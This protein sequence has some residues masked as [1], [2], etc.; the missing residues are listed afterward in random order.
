VD[1]LNRIWSRVEKPAI[2]LTLGAYFVLQSLMLFIPR[3]DSIVRENPQI[4]GLFVSVVLFYLFLFVD[5]RLPTE[6][7]DAIRYFDNLMSAVDCAFAKQP[8]AKRIDILGHSTQT[9]YASIADRLQEGVELRVLIRDPKSSHFLSHVMDKRKIRHERQQI[10]NVI[11]IWGDIA[12]RRS[13]GS[14]KMYHY[15]FEP[16]FYMMTLND[17]VVLLGLLEPCQDRWGFRRGGTFVIDGRRDISRRMVR[18]LVGWFAAT[19]REK[20]TEIN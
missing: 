4:L 8:G 7:G 19:V 2:Y 3:L 20:C 10:R 15:D 14:C 16:T 18:D 13:V 5:R 9:F 6:T 1:S 12:K 17:R 11:T